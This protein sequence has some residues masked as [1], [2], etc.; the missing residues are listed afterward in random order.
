MFDGST[1]I[2]KYDIKNMSLEYLAKVVKKTTRIIT[3]IILPI[4][5]NNIIKDLEWF[6]KTEGN[7]EEI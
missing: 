3:I 4:T 5:H 7:K 6:Y 1:E 2:L